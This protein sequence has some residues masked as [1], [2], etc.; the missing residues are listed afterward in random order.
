[1]SATWLVAL[2]LVALLAAV[3]TPLFALIAAVAMLG[4]HLAGYDLTVVAVEFYRLS[5]LPGLIAIP[6]FTLAGYLLGE[7]GAPRRLVRLSDALLGWLPGGLAIVALVV[8]ALFTAFTGASG[9]TIVA[10]GALLFPALAQARYPEQFNLGLITS[11]GSLGLLFAPS[12]PLILYGFVAGQLETDPP[13]TVEALFLAGL[14]PGLLMVVLLSGY[15]MWAGRGA[16]RTRAFDARETWA[17]VR[18]AGW[19]IPLPFLVLGGIYSGLFAVGEAAAIT[20]LYVLVVVVGVRRE[21]PLRGLPQ[22]LS[23][24]MRLVGAI[25]LILGA[26]L[27]LSNWLI[28]IQVPE[29]L[30]EWMQ[31]RVTSPWAFLLLLNVFLLVAGMLLDVFS[32]IVILVPLLVPVAA[33]YGIDPVHLGIVLLA[34]L[35]LGYMTPPVGMNLFIASYRFDRPVTELMRACIPFFAILAV[36]VLLITWWPWLSLA[37]V[38]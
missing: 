33:R 27:A 29:R 24:A 8:C 4:V 36:A 14:L 21:I 35:Q 30:F 26:A 19:E 38:R 34:N 13:V 15:A 1:M 7:S 23:K 20:A 9:V 3:G 10:M 2:V 18:D 11:S 28:D 12:L 31:A 25:L 37:L 32:A 5:E 6:L 17:A 16:I 22:V